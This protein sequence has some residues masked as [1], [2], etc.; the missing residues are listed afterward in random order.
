[1]E[2]SKLTMFI[3]VKAETPAEWMNSWENDSKCVVQ[4]LCDV[5]PDLSQIDEREID[6]EESEVFYDFEELKGTRIHTVQFFGEIDRDGIEKLA[7]D[8][9]FSGG[10]CETLGILGSSHLPAVSFEQD[11]FPKSYVSFYACPLYGGDVPSEPSFYRVIKAIQ[12]M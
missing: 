8:G 4:I 11:S 3:A 6:W 9:Y 7:R 10:Y 5:A 1:M 2:T 12:N